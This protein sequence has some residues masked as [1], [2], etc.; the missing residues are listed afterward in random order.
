M[1]LILSPAKRLDF[2][3]KPKFD[4]STQPVFLKE[5][6][7]LIRE[8]RKRSK[9][10]LKE[11]MGISGQ[12]AELN[13][14]RYQNWQ[15]PFTN[16]NAKQAALA[17]NGE[18]YEGLDANTLSMDDMDFAQNHMF[19]L[20][21]LHGILRP[22]DLIQPYRLEMGSKFKTEQWKNLYDFWGNK[23]TEVINHTGD[24]TLIN[25]A[26]QEYFKAV[27]RKE[28]KADVITPVFKELKGDKLKSVSFYAKKARGL[29]SRFIIQNRIKDP[30]E[31]KAFDIDGY[32]YHES[33]SD[34]KNWLFTR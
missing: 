31:I 22:L 26:S 13:A 34:D 29:M 15:R 18:V 4:K 23:I 3:S 5:S 24:A 32:R 28:L 9:S 20:S 17:F 2:E 10:E 33:L 16:D 6:E 21:G 1:Q 7:I 14:E 19:I 30:E 11:M 12:L 8:L 25:L 27:H